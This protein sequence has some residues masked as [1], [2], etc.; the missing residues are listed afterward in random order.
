MVC[1]L[2]WA[3]TLVV[4]AVATKEWQFWATGNL[5]GFSMGAL[6]TASRV[7]A[8]LFSP[9]HKAGEFF[10]FYGMAQKLAVIVGL[11]TQFILGMMGMEFNVAIGASAIFFVIG[12]FLMFTI[13]EK[14]GRITA[15]R[16]AREHIRKHHDYRGEIGDSV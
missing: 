8:G 10:G 13:N 6:G 15:L 3:V 16:A 4:G 9:Q 14:E 12:F 11:G 5:V 7:M 2:I 1:L